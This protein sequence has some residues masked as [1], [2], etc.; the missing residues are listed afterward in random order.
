MRVLKETDM[1]QHESP[2]LS[3]EKCCFRYYAL[4]TIAGT[5]KKKSSSTVRAQT[6]AGERRKQKLADI[7]SA[8]IWQRR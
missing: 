6:V 5:S 7:D 3:I 8:A 2:R 4:L 1:W